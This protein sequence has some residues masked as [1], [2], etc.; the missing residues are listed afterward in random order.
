MFALAIV[1]GLGAP[2]AVA[3]VL[4]IN[5]LTDGLPAVALTQDPAAAGIH[6]PATRT[7]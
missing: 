2:M 1:A 7:R 3:Q 6:E 4:L 5:V